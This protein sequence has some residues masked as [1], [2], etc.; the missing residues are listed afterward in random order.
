MLY[1][2]VCV[3]TH[4]YESESESHSVMSDCLR[5]HELYSLWNSPGQ[6]T[7]VGSHSLFH[8]NFPTQGSI[9]GLLHCRRTLCQLSHQGSLLYIYTHTYIYMKN[10][11]GLKISTIIQTRCNILNINKN[12]GC[13]KKSFQE[14]C[15]TQDRAISF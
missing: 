9:L 8:R 7:G 5:P 13:I 11:F 10:L 4:T 14:K 12:P 6:N 1:V 3:Y 15:N 2:Y